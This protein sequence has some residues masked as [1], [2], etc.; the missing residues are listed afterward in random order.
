MTAKPALTADVIDWGGPK[1]ASGQPFAPTEYGAAESFVGAYGDRVRFDFRRRAWLVW[2]GYRWRL[3]PDEEV[4][5]LLVEHVRR[6]QQRALALTDTFE[7]NKAITHW[8][9]FDRRG[10]QDNLLA[11]AAT[12]KPVATAGDTWDADPML[13]GVENGVVELRTGLLRPGRPED[14]ITLSAGVPFD[15]VATCPRW[16]QFLSEIFA[17]D[18]ELVTWMQTFCG[19]LLTGDVSEQMFVI[20]W[21]AGANGK[22]TCFSTLASVFGSYAYNL[23]FSAFELHQ[24]GAIPNDL[25]ALVH[26]RFVTASESGESTRLNESRLKMLTGGDT[27]TARFL[28]GEFFEFRPVAKF[29]LFTNSKPTVRDDSLGMWRRI[30]LV[31]FTQTFAINRSLGSALATE[32][33]GI[34]RWAIEG[35]L[36]WQQDGLTIPAAVQAATREYQADS[37]H[38]AQFLAGACVVGPTE[39]CR[40]GELFKAYKGWCD[41]EDL[42]PRE[43]FNQRRFGEKLKT[44]FDSVQDS[45]GWQYIGVGLR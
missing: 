32:G 21:G 18:V 16:A 10:A 6:E 31:P 12:I 45:K 4:R 33:P 2:Q 5:R 14:L 13:L 35:C 29:V 25:A 22:S 11:L 38:L 34:L 24:R 1:R 27:V 19:Y 28:H 23:P 43:R 17:G 8:I 15:P 42:S 36:R 9:R 44:R 26:R 7:K 39:S 3:D 20:A 37:D 41:S 40:A 30:R